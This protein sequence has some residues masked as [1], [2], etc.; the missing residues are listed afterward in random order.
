MARVINLR[1]YYPNYTDDELVEVSDEVV[2][3]LAQWDRDERATQRMDR[4]YRSYYSL[5]CVEVAD[6]SA[7][8]GFDIT[9]EELA[10]EQLR[11]QLSVTISMLPEKQ[12]RRIRKH[13]Y[14]GMSIAAIAKEEQV[15]L[16]SI[17]LSQRKGLATLR[18]IIGF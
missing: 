1:D 18:K 14:E 9:D 15:S 13:Y 10:R 4:R 2:Q 7:L 5:S 12:A 3:Q 6:M 11:E 17:S 8:N 16:N